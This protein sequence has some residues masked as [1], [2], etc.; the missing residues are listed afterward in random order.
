M[1]W[2]TDTL[3]S[4]H[5]VTKYLDPVDH[6]VLDAT[7]SFSTKLVNETGRSLEKMGGTSI[8]GKA[9]SISK[10]LSQR[11]KDQGIG[12]WLGRTAVSA[13]TI[14]AGG[15]LGG[16]EASGGA[17]EGLGGGATYY[18]AGGGA[19]SDAAYGTSAGVDGGTTYFEAGGGYVSPSD[20]AT[21][22]TK[23]PSLLS[24]VA[25]SDVA[26]TG[27]TTLAKS[28]LEKKAPQTQAPTT[29][30]V[31]A[32]PDAEQQAEAKRRKLAEQLARR[33]RTASIMTNE[34]G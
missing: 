34:G 13:G 29:R 21:A 9:G 22:A 26:K 10:N 14:M 5:D 4:V 33:G 17:G 12:G 7:K 28:A 23:S 31:V 20:G 32:M 24:Q 11:D 19:V 2:L 30:P 3:N 16:T 1:G 6:Y 18:E 25:N 15:A 8:V 27:A